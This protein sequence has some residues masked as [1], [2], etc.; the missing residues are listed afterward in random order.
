MNEN[1][2]ALIEYKVLRQLA[3]HEALVRLVISL[4]PESQR[5]AVSDSLQ[6]SEFEI[7]DQMLAHLADDMPDLASQIRKLYD[8]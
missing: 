3:S 4:F 7:F 6:K 8:A 5:Q 1:P 2:N